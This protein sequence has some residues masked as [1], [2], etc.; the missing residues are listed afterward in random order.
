MA[1][2]LGQYIEDNQKF[3]KLDD[4]EMFDGYFMSS[5]II[6]N[7]F[8]DGE[9]TVEYTLATTKGKQIV[10]TNGTLGVAKLLAAAKAKDRVRISRSGLGPKTTYT[11]LSGEKLGEPLKEDVPF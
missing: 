8:K 7:R 1:N 9:Q 2:D 6:P 3:L 4:G 5:K 11:I 10:W